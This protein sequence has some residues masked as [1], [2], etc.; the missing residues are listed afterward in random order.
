MQYFFYR[1]IPL[2]EL[3]WRQIELNKQQRIQEARLSGDA[4]AKI[5][6]QAVGTIGL[7]PKIYSAH[8][9]RAGFVTSAIQSGAPS[10]LV[11]AQTGHASDV[12][13]SRYVRLGNLFKENAVSWM[14]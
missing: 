13:M 2:F 1:N 3:L 8:S 11:R 12:T 10:H 14:L 5:V 6:K 4:V 7:D 9:L